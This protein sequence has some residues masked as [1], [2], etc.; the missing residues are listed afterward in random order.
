M[1][2]IS[3]E[4]KKLERAAAATRGPV[5]KPTYVDSQR[6]HRAAVALAKLEPCPYA[7][8]VTKDQVKLAPPLE[9]RHVSPRQAI[10][11]IIFLQNL[12]KQLRRQSVFVSAPARSV[13]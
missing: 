11:R 10:D 7:G 6:L 9:G 2:V 8:R 13:R 1:E 4:Q 12:S 3:F 5:T